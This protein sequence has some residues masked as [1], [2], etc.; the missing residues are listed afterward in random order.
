MS[1]PKIH[2]FLLVMSLLVLRE[3]DW[4]GFGIFWVCIFVYR[5]FGL[6]GDQTYRSTR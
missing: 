1:R 5:V 6:V 2:L 3:W 4:L